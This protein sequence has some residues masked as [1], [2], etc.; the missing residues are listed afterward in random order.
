MRSPRRL[1]SLLAQTLA[2]H[3]SLLRAVSAQSPDVSHR[4]EIGATGGM[5]II[6]VAGAR[7]AVV[8]EQ[9]EA[10]A[11]RP[12]LGARAGYR[13]TRRLAVVGTLER[14]GGPGVITDSC[15]FGPPFPRATGPDTITKDLPSSF[16][17]T[18]VTTLRAE[19]VP[20]SR[21]WAEGRVYA[22]V[23]R[24][25]YLHRYAAVGGVQGRLRIGS[26]GRLYLIAEAEAARYSAPVTHSVRYFQDGIPAGEQLTPGPGR[27]RLDAT[28]RIGLAGTL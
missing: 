20:W 7:M 8:C 16:Q 26:I 4:I 5:A 19:L 13:L 22:G 2:L 15:P 25:W 12:A 27:S 14:V 23:G 1:A 17:E 28:L 6:S 3:A 21:S 9:T 18:T 11:D 10:S 24:L